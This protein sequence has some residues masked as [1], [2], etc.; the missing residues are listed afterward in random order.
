MF[1]L[2]GNSNALLKSVRKSAP[3]KPLA[4]RNV[5]TKEPKVGLHLHW[6]VGDRPDKVNHS[7]PGKVICAEEKALKRKD[8]RPH[9]NKKPHG[10]AVSSNQLCFTLIT[11]SQTCD[12]VSKAAGN[13]P[14]GSNG[15]DPRDQQK[16]DTGHAKGATLGYARWVEMRGPKAVRERHVVNKVAVENHIG[17][18]KPFGAPPALKASA[19]KSLES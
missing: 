5:R 16:S 1:E 14:S 7:L 18:D 9:Y 8:A 6:S 19:K 15:P 11:K 10:E 3:E 12:V 13:A 2:F 17:N 4:N